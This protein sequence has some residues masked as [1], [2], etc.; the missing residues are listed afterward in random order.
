MLAQWA[1]RRSKVL[2]PWSH[3]PHLPIGC[4]CL[5]GL[6]ESLSLW[7]FLNMCFLQRSCVLVFFLRHLQP[8]KSSSISQERL[9]RTQG[10]SQMCSWYQGYI[11]CRLER[12]ELLEIPEDAAGVRKLFV[13]YRYISVIKKINWATALEIFS[14]FYCI[15]KHFVSDVRSCFSTEE[16]MSGYL[17]SALP[18]E[19]AATV[20]IMSLKIYY[21]DLMINNNY[22]LNKITYK[23]K[24]SK[25]KFFLFLFLWITFFIN[26]C[27]SH[28][29]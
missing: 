17:R 8:S 11:Q 27:N 15:F 1:T 20:M 13:F 14:T 7:L 25:F 2:N 3:Y 16:K 9:Q 4:Q 6:L 24:Q 10:C 5:P 18:F 23:T 28:I 29:Q 22:I 12:I 21:W 19:L 26:Y